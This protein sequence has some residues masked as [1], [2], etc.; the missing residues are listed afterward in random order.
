MDQLL[1]SPTTL[2]YYDD[3]GNVIQTADGV[4]DASG[5]VTTSATASYY[6]GDGR[7]IAKVDGNSALCI[8]V[9]DAAGNLVQKTDYATPV[10][11]PIDLTKV[12][13][14]P[15]MN[16]PSGDRV[17]TYQYDLANR[18]TQTTLP[19]VDVTTPNSTSTFTHNVTIGAT[20]PDASNKTT[21]TV[22]AFLTTWETQNFSFG[23]HLG[24]RIANS[25]GPFTDVVMGNPST[26]TYSQT[27][28]GLLSGTYE[29]VLHYQDRTGFDVVVE[30][31]TLDTSKI[32]NTNVT[33]S[34]TGL[35]PAM[36]INLKLTEKHVYNV[37]GDEVETDDRAGNRTLNYY[38]AMHRKVASVDPLGYL[39]EW[40]Y[41]HQGNQ[42]SERRYTMALDSPFALTA[43]L[44]PTAPANSGVY[45]TDRY[46]NAASWL[47]SEVGPAMDIFNPDTNTLNKGARI[48]S[49]YVYDASGRQVAKSTGALLLANNQSDGSKAVTEYTYYDPAGRVQ[50]TIDANRV[51]TYFTYDAN[52]NVT[53]RYHYYGRLPDAFNVLGFSGTSPTGLYID[54]KYYLDLLPQL[55]SNGNSG[56]FSSPNFDWSR[57]QVDQFRYD[58][59]NRLIEN[60]DLMQVYD[61]VGGEITGNHAGD[62][63]SQTYKYDN[64][65]NRTYVQDEDL[66]VTR[67]AYD[68]KAHIIESEVANDNSSPA[69]TTS[70]FHYDVFGNLTLGYTGKNPNGA[71]PAFN[72]PA[73][74]TSNGSQITLNWTVQNAA[75]VQS[76]VVYDTQNSHATITDLASSGYTS[77]APMTTPSGLASVVL[78]APAIAHAFYYRVVTKDAAGNLAWTAE[79][80]LTVI[81]G[82]STTTPPTPPTVALI[83]TMGSAAGGL[84]AAG[85]ATNFYYTQTAYNALDYKINSNEKDGSYRQYGTDANGNIVVTTNYGQPGNSR[86][87]T[88]YTAYDARNRV[89]AEMNGWVATPDSIYNGGA[90]DWNTVANNLYL[91]AA[92]DVG[93]VASQL[94]QYYGSTA[95]LG[96]KPPPWVIVV[97]TKDPT[98]NAITN[99]TYVLKNASLTQERPVT[100]YAYDINNNVISKLLPNSSA[101]SVDMNDWTYQY[102]AMNHQVKQTDPIGFNTRTY[103]DQFGD[104]TAISTPNAEGNVL[105]SDPTNIL[106]KLGVIRKYYD[107]QGHLIK[108][109]DAIGTVT[110]YAYDLFGRKVSM[111]D[112]RGNALLSSDAAIDTFTS[113]QT[114]RKQLGVVDYSYKITSTVTWQQLAAILYGSSSVVGELQQELATVLGPTVSQLPS[115]TVGST[116]TGLPFAISDGTNDY[117]ISATNA[118]VTAGTV[119]SAAAQLNSGE[120]DYLSQAY[121]TRYTYDNRDRLTSVE[122][123]EGWHLAYDDAQVYIDERGRLGFA[124]LDSNGK[125]LTN[126]SGDPIGKSARQLT[127][128]DRKKLR[129]LYTTTYQYDGRGD[130]TQTTPGGSTVKTIVV[131]DELKRITYTQH[132][133]LDSAKSG[134][135]GGA[136][137]INGATDHTVYDE[138]GNTVTYYDNDGNTRNY[139]YNSFGQLA[140]EQDTS[141]DKTNSTVTNYKYDQFGR[142]WIQSGTNADGKSI[143]IQRTYDDAGRLITINDLSMHVR[144][145]YTYYL[146]GQIATEHVTNTTGVA[147]IPSAQGQI[148]NMTF[149]Y[150]SLGRTA[151][152]VDSYTGMQLN[153]S[154]DGDGNILEVYTDSGWDP[155]HAAAAVGNPNYRYYDHKY[156]YVPNPGALKVFSD[157]IQHETSIATDK[158]GVQTI[159][160]VS[161]YGYDAAGNRITWRDWH[162]AATSA[163]SSGWTYSIDANDRVVRGISDNSNDGMQEWQYDPSGNITTYRTGTTNFG[164]SV[165]HY[166]KYTKTQYVDGLQ[167]VVTTHN[168]SPS[169]TDQTQTY[170]YYLSGRPQTMRLQTTDQNGSSDK[171]ITYAY[172]GDGREKSETASANEVSRSLYDVNNN[173]QS[174]YPGRVGNMTE[175][176]HSD[177]VNDNDGHILRRTRDDGFGKIETRDYIYVNGNPVGEIGKNGDGT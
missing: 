166:Y 93:A 24:Y 53:R 48:T 30:H 145:D 143:S 75:Q 156:S 135:Y 155:L 45:R 118:N 103:F 81:A 89:T 16:G 174:F 21:L 99:T 64:D 50:L 126:S 62:D 63:L 171:T 79:Q 54:E 67:N 169:T 117:F 71:L 100:R 140:Q 20:T 27:I 109:V 177:F 160:G 148:R 97:T 2:T 138:F 87:I 162:G 113:Y 121:T 23:L 124:L 8:Y 95:N 132:S 101:T 141:A 56:L 32:L 43:D 18:L 4:T 168:E 61:I 110:T 142:L 88:T 136:S 58:A 98:T 73:S 116:L 9:Y 170:T 157:V 12:P 128:D 104:V 29:F 91:P 122:Q 13:S 10:A 19:A 3:N 36:P 78:T 130:R 44:R 114:L 60:D 129:A 106:N 164:S 57:L 40:D 47:I 123:P 175:D 172:Y 111:T 146:D 77:T 49:S 90:T 1:A 35:V 68:A 55:M 167:R 94:Q 85:K 158:S 153:Y 76:W 39:T 134:I 59:L 96:T 165:T 31:Q 86:G 82:N 107:L 34:G 51:V 92:N 154:Y 52:G 112:G 15:S 38:D 17:T 70:V 147:G 149:S 46:Y 14:V 152:W 26:G 119:G 150:D 42:T 137:I 5:Y 72:L 127:D 41:D 65:D 120:R 22:Q 125:P 7:L 80:T 144:T 131:Y 108:D 66:H 115:I 37:Y 163:A 28:V 83:T 173:I 159:S 105:P 151:R 161:D 69:T 25:V 176:P 74:V 11:A 33:F 139:A 6:D 133:P 84:T 102:D